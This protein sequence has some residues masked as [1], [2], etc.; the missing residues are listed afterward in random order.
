M[1][2][3]PHLN[4]GTTGRFPAASGTAAG[5]AL[6]AVVFASG[7]LFAAPAAAVDVKT[8]TEDKVCRVDPKAPGS[9]LT[10]FWTTLIEKAKQQRIEELD[11]ADPGLKAA[12]EAYDAN[13]STA[14]DPGVLQDRIAAA[15][16][17][18]GLGMLIATTAEEAGVPGDSP[19]GPVKTAY[20]APEARDAAAA[21][22]PDPAAKVEK[23]LSDVAAT[24][25]RLDRIKADLFAEQSGQFNAIQFGMRD[26][27]VACADALTPEEKTFPWPLAI[28]GG[29]VAA[30]LLAVAGLAIRNHRRPVRHSKHHPKR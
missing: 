27:L 30:A 24:G 10:L 11:E 8:D 12:I 2:G 21:V 3:M 13:P 16:G 6:T 4:S 9:D 26:Q 18:E 17:Q 23:A 20:T 14:D 28:I 1:G 7:G 29:A 25:N 22:G 15:G 19:D 5:V